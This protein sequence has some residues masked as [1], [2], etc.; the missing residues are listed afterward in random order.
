MPVTQ[1]TA[2]LN[3]R[4][5]DGHGLTSPRTVVIDGTVIGDDPSGAE[6]VDVAGAAL[7]PG[8]IDAHVHLHG[9]QSLDALAAWGVT[10]GLDMACW[11]A[12][13]VASLR[14]VTGSADFRT[15]GLPAIGPGG[16]H[17]RMPGMPREAVILTPDDARRHVAARAAEGADYIKGVAEAPGA[18]GPT[19]EALGA[20]VAAAREHGLKTVIHAASVG[21]YSLAVGCGAEFIT[22]VPLIGTIR[23]EDIAAMKAAGQVAVPTITMMEGM[24]ASGLIPGGNVSDLLRSLAALKDAGVE[25]LAGTD[26][27]AEPGAPFPVPHGEGLHHEFGLMAH[28]GL[29]PVEI[30]R[31]ATVLPARAFG[32]TDRGSIAP[33]LRADLLLVDGDPTADISATR[34]I[35][36]IWCAGTPVT[37]AVRP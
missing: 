2:L 37:P 33:G 14:E 6:Q 9:P 28:A 8:L 1:R 24:I 16:N 19:A 18:G 20:L 5:F 21:A 3:A 17:A 32:L 4:V 22:H 31:S 36:A 27:N 26:A 11:P 34:S 25:I 35:R 7:L 13:L 23:E 15:A 12:E 10:T 30:L 29:T